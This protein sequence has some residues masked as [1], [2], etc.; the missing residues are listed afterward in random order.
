MADITNYQSY[1]LYWTIPFFFYT[2]DWPSKSFCWGVFLLTNPNCTALSPVKLQ[3]VWSWILEDTNRRGG[4]ELDVGV[5]K[6]NG[7][8]KS[9]ILI[10]FSRINHPFW[11]TTIFGNPHVADGFLLI[12]IGVFSTDSPT[13]SCTGCFKTI[14]QQKWFKH[15]VDSPKRVVSNILLKEEMPDNHLTCMKPCK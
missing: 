2:Q 8:P 3:K 9:S 5:S 12:L 1:Q 14:P 13:K 11:G 4:E 10:G 7:I 15:T 6:N